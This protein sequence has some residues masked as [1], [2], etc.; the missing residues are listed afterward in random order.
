MPF[1]IGSSVV[2]AARRY[3]DAPA[4]QLLSHVVPTNVV[5]V[6]REISVT[7]AE[8]DHTLQLPDLGTIALGYLVMS[9]MVSNAE[10]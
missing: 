3:V 6:L 4:S 5:S 8:E 9:L 7:A 10:A 2:A 1:S